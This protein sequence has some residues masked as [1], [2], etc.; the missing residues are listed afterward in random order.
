MS[1]QIQPARA[2]GSVRGVVTW[3][4]EVRAGLV[5][6]EQG[7]KESQLVVTRNLAPDGLKWITREVRV[8]GHLTSFDLINH[9]ES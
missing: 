4:A 9:T 5:R 7:I 3:K 2:S 1:K 6:E 8:D